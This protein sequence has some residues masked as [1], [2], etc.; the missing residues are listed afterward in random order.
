[1]YVNAAFL[2]NNM[3][4]V[5]DNSAPLV[6]T[7][8]GFYRFE[9]TS[10]KTHRPKG[11]PDYQF[12]YISVGKV[13]FNFHGKN[14][15]LQ[16]GT[17]VLFRP[18]EPQIY[19]YPKEERTEVYWIHFTGSAVEEILECYQF[20]KGQNVFSLGI[21]QELR[22]TYNSVIHELHLCRPLYK[23]TCA[24]FLH[25]I[26]LISQ[27]ILQENAQNPTALQ[28]LNDIEQ[29]MQ[30]FTKNYNTQINIEAYAKSINMS[31]C[32]FIRRFK[33]IM[34]VTPMQYII[35][36]RMTNAKTLLESKTYNISQT[37]NHVGY[38][39]PLYFSRLFTKFVGISPKEY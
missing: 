34:K 13:H 36:L 21:S 19:F 8:S 35:A 1:M 30:Y 6:V 26:L 38:D 33:E 24:V 2:H 37:A 27:R 39:N 7:S 22:Q 4:P 16:Q 9:G 5:V 28:S 31:T 10:L 11:R 23:E 17:A 14:V 32:W 25:Q 3:L 29:A 18:N 12:F 20:S 15:V